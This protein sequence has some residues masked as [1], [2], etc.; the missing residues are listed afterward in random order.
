[1]VSHGKKQTRSE[2]AC[3]N[4]R[5]ETGQLVLLFK[6]DCIKCTPKTALLKTLDTHFFST[7]RSPPQHP[8]QGYARHKV[9]TGEHCFPLSKM[10]L[11]LQRQQISSTAS[12]ITKQHSRYSTQNGRVDGSSAASN[13]TSFLAGINQICLVQS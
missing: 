7:L 10:S 4:V 5:T 11:N 3:S 6:F 12:N 2:A 9:Q 13:H 1:M 8:E